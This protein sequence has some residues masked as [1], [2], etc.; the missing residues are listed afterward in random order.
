MAFDE[1]DEVYRR[2][3]PVPCLLNQQHHAQLLHWEA[4][5][6]TVPQ[7]AFMNAV[8]SGQALYLVCVTTEKVESRQGTGRQALRRS[9]G[10][11]SERL[12]RVGSI[13]E[14]LV[15]WATGEVMKQIS[16]ATYHVGLAAHKTTRR[17]FSDP[18]QCRAVEA[19]VRDKPLLT[20]YPKPR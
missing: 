17:K 3:C 15:N 14:E 8:D 9:E 5:C 13:P 16:P 7:M 18:G 12:R 10:V 11:S 1:N 6:R 4:S 2:S 19:P 20:R